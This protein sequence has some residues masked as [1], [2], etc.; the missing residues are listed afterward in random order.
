[1]RSFQVRAAIVALS[2]IV[3]CSATAPA[4]AQSAD[5]VR[6][7][8]LVV[9]GTPA[10]IAAAVAAARR[11]DE[12]TLV[13]GAADL[14]G[15]LTE[16]MMDQWDLNVAPS[17]VSI[18]GGLFS[19]MY[20]RLGD[21]F[22][23]QAAA[24]TFAEMVAGEPRIVVRYDERPLRVETERVTDGRRITAVTFANVT[25]QVETTLAAPLVVDATDFAD[26]AALAGARYDVGRQDTGLDERMQAVTLM[27]TVADVDWHALAASYDDERFG[28]G[29]V[30]N[31]RAWGYSD[32]LRAYRPLA[33]T[34]LVR[35]LNLGLLQDGSLTVNAIDV[36]GIDGLDPAELENA[37]RLSEGEAYR[38]VAYLRS[39]LPG[40]ERARV[41]GFAP[42]V[43]V[44][45]TRHIAGLERLT[46]EDVWLG[47]VPVDSIGLASYPI[48]LHPVDAT[49][50]PAFA[51]VRHVYGIPFGT[52]V[53]AGLTN[54]VLAGPAISATHLASGSAR[55][56]PTTIEEGEAAGT[57]AAF[58][59]QSGFDFVELATRP[60]L[61]ARLR[62]DLVSAGVLLG[63]P[64]H[65]LIAHAFA[66]AS[67]RYAAFRNPT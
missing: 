6:P 1:M 40:F 58:A 57:A 63:R 46:A 47:R 52:L 67:R 17:G 42:A 37:R 14:G 61:V 4:G 23:P 5:L 10:G 48:D 34:V 45:E 12:V 22:T 56:I 43:Y 16:A 25:S 9:G 36:T 8:V 18:E 62:G 20:A 59:R 32:L 35:D 29:G 28:P 21:V 64:A 60:A 44:R 38:L 30:V 39:R 65:P 54:L 7:D 31:R 19:E 41:A 50:G 11:G 55:V 26:V 51:P 27:F 15:T 24:R 13:S 66:N 53:P 3:L 49:G 2:A 33:P